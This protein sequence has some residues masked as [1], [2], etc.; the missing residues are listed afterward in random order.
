MFRTRRQS[1][2]RV[3]QIHL[4]L[5]RERIFDLHGRIVYV[6]EGA[7][8][9]RVL[10][11]RVRFDLH[12]RSM[13]TKFVTQFFSC[14]Q[15]LHSLGFAAGPV[16]QVGHTGARSGNHLHSTSRIVS[17]RGVRDGYNYSPVIR[18]SGQSA[19]A[20]ATELLLSGRN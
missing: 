9:I 17:S 6:T 4:A 5:C 15:W 11:E 20:A 1:A 10:V 8:S 16:T 14:R 2:W 7:C 18:S 12:Q 19:K 13:T 3:S